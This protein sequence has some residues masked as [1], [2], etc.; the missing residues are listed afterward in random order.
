MYFTR[1]TLSFPSGPPKEL[2]YALRGS[3][4]PQSESEGIGFKSTKQ[5]SR[6]VSPALFLAGTGSLT[7]RQAEGGLCV[8][9]SLCSVYVC[10][11]C[12]P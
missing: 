7:T 8:C 4:W 6:T 2:L 12:S 3:E 5:R 9:G 10:L 1:V 11:F